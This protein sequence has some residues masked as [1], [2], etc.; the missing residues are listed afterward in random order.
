MHPFVLLRPPASQPGGVG[1]AAFFWKLLFVTVTLAS[2]FKGGEVTPLFMIGATLG[3]TMGT[4]LGQDVNL[5]AALGLISVFAGATNTPLACTIMG[6]ELFGGSKPLYFALSCFVAYLVSG[7]TGIYE[8]QAVSGPKLAGTASHAQDGT[9][10]A[11]HTHKDIDFLNRFQSA[12]KMHASVK[13]TDAGGSSPGSVQADAA[14]PS[15]I[16]PSSRRSSG[17]GRIGSNSSMHARLSVTNS[18]RTAMPSAGRTLTWSMKL[19]DES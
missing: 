16:E 7:I 8:A 10:G 2:G 12:L 3:N 5:F 15:S 13:L 1:M 6:I 19:T 9:V 18:I 4:A 11:W 17:R 14:E